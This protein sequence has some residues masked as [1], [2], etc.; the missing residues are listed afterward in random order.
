VTGHES[1]D[2]LDRCDDVEL[3][4]NGKAGVEHVLIDHV[5]TARAS[6]RHD[7]QHGSALFRDPTNPRP[8]NSPTDAH[9]SG[10]F[11]SQSGMRFD[12]RAPQLQRSGVRSSD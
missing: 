5:D 12:R 2:G 6:R 11:I 1:D 7:L 4:G 9:A 3:A 8:P 10:Y